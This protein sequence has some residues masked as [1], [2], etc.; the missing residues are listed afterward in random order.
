MMM[1]PLY[2]RSVGGGPFAPPLLS[3]HLAL[4]HLAL[5]G[6]LLLHSDLL[7]LL[8]KLLL[9]LLDHSRLVVLDLY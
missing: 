4:S 6:L 3:F 5:S 1:D 8:A 2:S 7:L 9:L